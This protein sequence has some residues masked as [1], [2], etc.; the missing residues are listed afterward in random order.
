MCIDYYH[1][2]GVAKACLCVFYSDISLTGIQPV[3]NAALL[4]AKDGT[5]FR[6]FVLAKGGVNNRPSQ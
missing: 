3:C 2:Q 4:L 5:E 6:A 1:C